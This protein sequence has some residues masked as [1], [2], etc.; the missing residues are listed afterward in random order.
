MTAL[1]GF[2][3]TP[4][5]KNFCNQNCV[6]IGICGD[7][8]LLFH[9]FSS[10]EERRKSG[11]SYFIEMQYCR[12]GQGTKIEKIV[13]VDA[14]EHWKNDALYIYGDDIDEFVLRYGNIFTGGIFNNRKSGILDVYGINYYSQE[15]TRL[16]LDRVKKTKPLDYQILLDW[17]EN[18]KECIGFYVLG[19]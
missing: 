19:I 17:L 6:P 5:D 10:Q 13:S 18:S 11:G 4:A 8:T 14:I 12:L 2:K 7:D 15:Q 9:T 1:A 16:I 3:D